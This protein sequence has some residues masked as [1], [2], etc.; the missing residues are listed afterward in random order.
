MDVLACSMKRKRFIHFNRLHAHSI[1]QVNERKRGE[2]FLSNQIQYSMTRT[3][4]LIPLRSSRFADD[5]D[6]YVDYGK[7]RPVK[8]NNN[9]AT[10]IDVEQFLVGHRDQSKMIST[11]ISNGI[12]EINRAN[13]NQSSHKINHTHELS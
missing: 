13:G 6:V 1:L 3:K 11:K 7:G 4:G 5:Y 10:F 9:E 12:M 8:M 2:V